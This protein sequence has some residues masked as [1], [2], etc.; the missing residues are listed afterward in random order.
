MS[1]PLQKKLQRLQ[2]EEDLNDGM[3]FV[4]CQSCACI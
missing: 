4:S 3:N 2:V 1:Q